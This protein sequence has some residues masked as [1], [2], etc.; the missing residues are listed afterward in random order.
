MWTLCGNVYDKSGREEKAV[1]MSSTS[2]EEAS[3]EFTIP[4]QMELQ[5]IC[6]S[7]DSSYDV[8]DPSEC[9]A[10][11]HSKRIRK[12]HLDSFRYEQDIRLSTSVKENKRRGFGKFERG[13]RREDK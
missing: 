8:C 4:S 3:G 9:S 5:V 10:S 12:R 1:L 7:V 2:Y 6:F 11:T 13:E